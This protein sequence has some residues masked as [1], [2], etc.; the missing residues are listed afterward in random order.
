M[1]DVFNGALLRT[2]KTPWHPYT[3]NNCPFSLLKSKH[4][5]FGTFSQPYF[6]S[7]FTNCLSYNSPAKG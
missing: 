6:K 7:T 4:A 5:Q 1:Y 2:L 3:D